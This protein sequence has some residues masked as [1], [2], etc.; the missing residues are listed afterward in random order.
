MD[1]EEILMPHFLVCPFEYFIEKCEY[2]YLCLWNGTEFIQI[3]PKE[4]KDYCKKN[5]LGYHFT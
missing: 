2:E 3:M 1:D 5:N 4:L